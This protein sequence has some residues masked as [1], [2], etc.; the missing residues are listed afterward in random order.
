METGSPVLLTLRTVCR[1]CLATAI[2]CLASGCSTLAYYA[3]SIGG[4]MEVMTQRQSIESLTRGGNADSD[5]V[6]TLGRVLEMLDFARDEL[7][8]PDNGSYRSYS[9]IRREFVLWN[10]FAAPQLALQPRQWCYLIVGCLAYRGYYDKTEALAYADRLKSEGFD[11][12]VGGV[13]AYSTLGWF[14][15]PVLNTM[16]RRGDIYLARVMFHELA[17]QKVYI[18]DD[19]EFNEAFADAVS[20]IATREWLRGSASRQE[21]EAFQQ[22]QVYEQQFFE[23]V[24]DFRRELGTL[25]ASRL[26]EARLLARKQEMFEA[27]R[28]RYRQLRSGWNGYNAYDDWIDRDL[29]NAKIAAFSTYRALVP[30]FLAL[31]AASGNHPDTF[32]ARVR[33][34]AAC[35]RDTRRQRLETLRVEEDC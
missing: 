8:L 18:K 4:H 5:T 21:F 14:R 15:D 31:Y 32:Y 13:T 19:T 3:Q 26:P 23:L 27:F 28:A 33:R 29:N 12:F 11:V 16:L 30:A 10:V 20:T 22:Q 34:L 17:H 35:D 24:F 25:Y 2:C 1:T 7:D 9:D 6:R